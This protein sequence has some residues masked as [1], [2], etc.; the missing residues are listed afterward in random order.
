VHYTHRNVEDRPLRHQHA[1]DV[2]R[3]RRLAER[4][5]HGGHHAQTLL[6]VITHIR[7]AHSDLGKQFVRPRSDTGTS[8]KAENAHD[9]VQ[10]LQVLEL[11]VSGAR[12]V[13][14]HRRHL[15]A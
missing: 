10:P 5:R 2:V 13:G 8:D 6:S 15:L 14:E 1:V 7:T 9:T 11:P 12:A 4:H 3:L